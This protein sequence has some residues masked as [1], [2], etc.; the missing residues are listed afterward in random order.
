MWTYWSQLPISFG[1]E[2]ASISSAL[3]ISS[4]TF[5]WSIINEPLI[6][7]DLPL[8]AFC[9]FSCLQQLNLYLPCKTVDFWLIIQGASSILNSYILSHP[10]TVLLSGLIMIIKRKKIQ[11]EYF[12]WYNFFWEG[13]AGGSHTW[14][15]PCGQVIKRALTL[16]LLDHYLLWVIMCYPR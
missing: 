5:H 4:L 11:F 1:C 3:I 15:C 14:R 9:Q 13:D 10:Q 6:D 16:L 12:T 8:L 2:I 7:P